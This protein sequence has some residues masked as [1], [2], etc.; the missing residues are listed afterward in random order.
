[1]IGILNDDDVW[2]PELVASLLDAFERAPNAVLA[3]G[4][5]DVI[6]D[7][8]VDEDVTRRTSR[9][10]GRDVLRAG[11]HQP[12][13]REALVSK[14]V[15]LAIAALFRRTALG[16]ERIPEE[17]AGAY[18]FYLAYRLCRDG[19]GAVFVSERLA[20]WRVHSTNL[21]AVASPARSEEVAHVYRILIR[22]Q[23]LDEIRDELVSAYGEVLW[24]V[25]ARHLRWGSR[26]KALRAA[27][28]SLRCGHYRSAALIPAFVVPKRLL[29]YGGRVRAQSLVR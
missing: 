5:H 23:R 26:V 10:W 16:A 11:V 28:G 18:D 8:R 2:R 29:V 19:G 6:V 13:W 4:D 20:G 22:D 9:Q 24:S 21:T 1:V 14:S 7:G 3:F 15:P 25:A 27:I 12:F 17:V